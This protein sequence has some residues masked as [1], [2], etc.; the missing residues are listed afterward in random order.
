M[1][2]IGI[3]IIYFCNIEES[4]LFKFVGAQLE[5]PDGCF[6][7]DETLE[8]TGSYKDCIAACVVGSDIEMPLGMILSTVFEVCIISYCR[9]LWFFGLSGH[10]I[11]KFHLF[12]PDLQF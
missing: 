2:F 11:A 4:L 7:Y 10:P 3:T 1:Y 8:T 6:T 12:I 5:V 9:S